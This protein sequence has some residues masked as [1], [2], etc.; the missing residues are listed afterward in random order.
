MHILVLKG[1]YQ[2]FYTLIPIGINDIERL[3]IQYHLKDYIDRLLAAGRLLRSVL[4]GLSKMIT[5]AGCAR[6][7]VPNDRRA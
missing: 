6:R 2:R 7:V 5:I 3:L 4:N 1:N